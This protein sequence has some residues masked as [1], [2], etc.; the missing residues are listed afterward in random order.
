MRFVAVVLI[1][2]CV[3]LSCAGQMKASHPAQSGPSAPT[4]AVPNGVWGGD[5][6]RMEVNDSG[7]DIE[8]D[9]ARGSI[10]QR[11][12]LDDKGRFKVQGIY[13]AETP[14]PAAVDGGLTASGVKATYTGTLSGSSLRLEVFIEGQD[15]PRTF[16]LVQGD[17]G[18]LAKCA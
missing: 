12:E 13:M 17:Q 3:G 14:A 10:S 4:K 15:M 7:A 1:T 8:F 9:C 5:H 16:D 6:I 11:L 18:H 2:A